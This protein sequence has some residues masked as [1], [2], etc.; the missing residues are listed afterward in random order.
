MSLSRRRIGWCTGLLLCVLVLASCRQVHVAQGEEKV[1][2]EDKAILGEMATAGV[3]GLSYAVVSDGKVIAQKGLGVMR[4][5]GERPV[6]A[7]T[8]FVLGSVA[9]SLTAVAI[10]QLVEAGRLSLDDPLARHL[11]ELS[12]SPA[13]RM[14]IR[15]LLSH[16]SGWSTWQGNQQQTD[17]SMDSAALARRVQAL[18]ERTPAIEAGRSFHYSNANYVL[19]GR[20]VEVASGQDFGVYLQT[21]LLQPLGMMDTVAL[22]AADMPADSDRASG[23]RPWFG[24]RTSDGTLLAGRGSAPQG[25]IL[26][27]A[28][29]MARFLAFLMDGGSGILSSSAKRQ[30]LSPAGGAAPA[31]GFGWYVDAAS[32]RAFHSGAS[33]GFESMAVLLPDQG[34]AAI[35]LINAGSGFGFGETLALRNSV[36][37][38]TLGLPYAGEKPPWGRQLAYLSL[39]L[40]SVLL[41]LASARV[42]LAVQGRAPGKR[43]LIASVSVLVGVLT[44]VAALPP[45]LGAPLA[46]IALYRPDLGV[47]LGALVAAALLW[48]LACLHRWRDRRP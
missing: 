21:R 7:R 45:Q 46:T 35:V 2:A 6:Q 4:Q 12:D 25:A 39:I 38:R 22:G 18:S 19:L 11:V 42:T 10:L 44:M 26:T 36:I 8:R 5:G 41:L 48:P 17:F 31:Y 15:Q 37:A 30:A 27:T 1:S 13:G 16:T 33:P 28:P 9:K 32:G 40:L 20:L 29:D 3:P 43:Q 34:R 47:M 23:H 24:T 14:T